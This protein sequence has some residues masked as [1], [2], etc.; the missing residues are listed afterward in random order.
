MLLG[1]S[2][3][4]LGLHVSPKMWILEKHWQRKRVLTYLYCIALIMQLEL[5]GRSS[6][7]KVFDGER[8]LLLHT[9]IYC[10][11]W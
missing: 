3:I 10:I 7:F 6:G 4:V 2:S 1:E 5:L 11:S 8:N 9:Y